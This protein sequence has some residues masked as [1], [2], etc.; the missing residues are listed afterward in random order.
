MIQPVDAALTGWQ[1][2]C[3]MELVFLTAS[4]GPAASAG[5]DENSAR[6]APLL[7]NG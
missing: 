7:A 5:G 4:Y 1:G 3:G 2:G 6:S